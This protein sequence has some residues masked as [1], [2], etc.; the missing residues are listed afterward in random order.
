MRLVICRSNPVAPDP[1][2]EKE[3]RSLQNHGYEVTILGWDR[4][5]V[6]PIREAR[7]QITMVRI[8]IKSGYAHGWL[9]IFPLLRWQ[10]G[11]LSWLLRHPSRFDVI[12]ACDFDTVLAALICKWVFRKKVV[13]D[14]FDFYA[15]HLRATPELLKR[16]IRR[17]DHWAINRVDAV[18]LVDSARQAQLLPAVPKR[19]AVVYNIPED[20]AIDAV[21]ADSSDPTTLRLAYVGLLQVERGLIQ[22]IEVVGS[23]PFWSLDLAGFGGDEN[24]ILETARRYPNITWHGRVSYE[25]ALQLDAGADVML[26]L[27]DPAIANHR[28]ASP[29]KV[30]E[31]LMLGKPVLVARGTNI[32]LLIERLKAGVVIQYGDSSELERGLSLLAEDPVLRQELGANGRQAYEREFNWKIMETRLLDLYR[33]L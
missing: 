13:Y 17:L 18:I 10:V 22:V 24:L 11:L 26:A 27:Y 31:A 2:V 29:N 14:I 30:F 8:P 5:G 16:L 7:D 23:H 15:D 12:H 4:S 28:Y 3:A 19:L 33:S 1:R 25:R 9:N 20:L 6:L 32:D 21:V